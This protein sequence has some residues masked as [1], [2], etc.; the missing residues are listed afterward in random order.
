[1]VKIE[2]QPLWERVNP[3]ET[4]RNPNQPK[5]PPWEREG[6]NLM[7]EFGLSMYMHID[8]LWAFLFI[9]IFGL[10]FVGLS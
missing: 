6:N 2:H 7:T 10:V 4:K 3:K 9:F 1:M 8:P 5:T